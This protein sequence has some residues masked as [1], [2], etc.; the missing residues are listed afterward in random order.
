MTT[1]PDDS[2][3]NNNNHHHDDA[4]IHHASFFVLTCMHLLLNIRRYIHYTYTFP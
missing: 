4:I 1:Q 2:I 3:E